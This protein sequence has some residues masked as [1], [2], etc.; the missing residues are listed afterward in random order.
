MK[1]ESL[2]E[3]AT[4][5]LRFQLPGLR[6]WIISLVFGVTVINILDRLSVSVL[7]PVIRDQL[8]LTNLAYA[9]V[10]TWFLLAYTLSQGA[11]GWMQDRIGARRGF[12]VSVTVWSLA[13][14]MH[15]W[16]R[17]F[18]SLCFFRVALGLGEGGN[19]PGAI[20]V[21]TDW[22]PKRERAF[23]LGIV[24]GGSSV[25]AMVAPPIVVWL[26]L[27]YGWQA[28]FLATG[29]L[30]FL[31]LVAWLVFYRARDRHPWL[32]AGEAAYIR[33]GRE[34]PGDAE[35][36][37]SE[38]TPPR[39]AELLLSRQAWAVIVA[40]LLV[41][42][43]W[44]LYILWLPEYLHKVRGLSM[45]QIGVMASLPFI[46][47]GIGGLAGGALSGWL[48]ARGWS[49]NWAR[50]SIIIVAAGLM[51]CG[52]LAAR[53]EHT[54]EAIAWISVVTFGFQMWISNVQILPSDLFPPQQVA[55]VAGLGGVGAGLG[56]MVFTLTTGWVVDHYSYGPIL[57]AAGLLGPLGTLALFFLL[58]RV[59][60]ITKD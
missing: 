50:K 41:D 35:R 59:E 44:W 57:V 53:A 43:V 3:A 32:S 51:S 29:S 17:G 58:G 9:E 4:A 42:P 11:S 20:K 18:G 16:A 30:G 34:Q 21:I 10:G 39:W 1:S 54:A 15:A 2:T 60:P 49:L 5:S 56:S 25:G 48:M 31:W 13:A 38:P 22:F 12:A 52:I 24:N 37:E 40:R 33:E 46:A 27:A 14:L 55:S 8:H 6:W 19:W 26:Q 7:A 45:Q 23:A 28:A 47:A 36:A